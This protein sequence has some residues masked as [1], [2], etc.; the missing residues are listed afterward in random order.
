MAI[1]MVMRWEK[2]TPEL[3][4]AARREVN[5]EGDKPKGGMFHVAS[6]EGDTLFVTDVWESAEELQ[7]F[8]EKRLMPGTAKLGIQTQPDIKVYPVH[9]IFTPAYRP[10]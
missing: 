10:A 6:F 1:M 2:V 4:E 5:W 7:D 3:Y 8:A 9:A